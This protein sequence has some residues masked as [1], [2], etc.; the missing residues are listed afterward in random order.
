MMIRSILVKG[1]IAGTLAVGSLGLAV[2]TAH[3]G[4][5][6]CLQCENNA[7]YWNDRRSSRIPTT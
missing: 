5:S 4:G 6:E 7:N 1:A 2:G 3:A